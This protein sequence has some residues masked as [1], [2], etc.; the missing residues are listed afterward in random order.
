VGNVCIGCASASTGNTNEQP[1]QQV[2]AP[3]VGAVV[4]LLPALT[5]LQ[6]TLLLGG[7]TGCQAQACVKAANLEENCVCD[8][9]QQAHLLMPNTSLAPAAR[10]NANRKKA[11]ALARI[12]YAQTTVVKV[13]R[14]WRQRAEAAR[15][16][17]RYILSTGEQLQRGLL[18][19]AFRAWRVTA[20]RE[21]RLRDTATRWVGCG[22]TVLWAV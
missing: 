20:D 4:R 2:H 16:F 17:R 11:S 13:L 19:D 5:C 7:V 6:T 1:T 18:R 3:I 22:G 9:R 8:S 14:A 21:A 10:A 15:G 12:H